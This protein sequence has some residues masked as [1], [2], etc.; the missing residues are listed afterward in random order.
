MDSIWRM[1]G[2]HWGFLLLSLWLPLSAPAAGGCGLGAG[3]PG[4]VLGYHGEC[5]DG[6]VHGV[7]EVMLELPAA[8]NGATRRARQFGWFQRGVPQGAH[9]VVATDPEEDAPGFAMLNSFDAYGRTNWWFGLPSAYWPKTGSLLASGPWEDADGKAREAG[10]FY[11]LAQRA[12]GSFYGEGRVMVADVINLAVEYSMASG[13]QSVEPGALRKHLASISIQQPLDGRLAGFSANGIF[14]DT[15]E[16]APA[17][18]TKPAEPEPT[19]GLDELI[20]RA[21]EGSQK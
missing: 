1:Q 4:V 2:A 14:P 18:S 6:R 16:E 3:R 15:G 17:A 12:D 11:A 10:L 19:P 21:M 9:I 8:A 20:R 5:L 7:A 13:V